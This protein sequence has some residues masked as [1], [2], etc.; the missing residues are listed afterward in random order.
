MRGFLKKHWRKLGLAAIALPILAFLGLCLVIGMGVRGAVSHAQEGFPGDPVTALI[1]VATSEEIKIAD[2]DRAI[3]ALG[4]LGS[5]EA[6]PTLQS[7]VTDG[8]CDHESLIC[9]YELEKAIAACSGGPNIG[10]VIWRHG[11]LAVADKGG[12]NAP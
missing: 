7:M 12:G 3:W 6:L 4:Q 11:D 1:S 5:P 2:R 9:Q 8:T 10:A